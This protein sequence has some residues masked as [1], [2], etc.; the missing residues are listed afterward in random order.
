MNIFEQ[1]FVALRELWDY[2][3]LDEALQGAYVVLKGKEEGPGTGHALCWKR[4]VLDDVKEAVV[5]HD[6]RDWL[7]VVLRT[8]DLGAILLVSVHLCPALSFADKRKSL[9]AIHA[10]GELLKVDLV[11][12]PGDYNCPAVGNSPLAGVLNDNGPW[13][14]YWASHPACTKTNFVVN[15]GIRRETAIDHIMVKG[16]AVLL[17][18]S[19]FSMPGTHLALYAELGMEGVMV[20]SSHWRRFRWRQ[21]ARRKRGACC[22]NQ[23]SLGMDDPNPGFD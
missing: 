2:K 19:T 15:N 13:K 11:L 22:S 4:W 5:V 8:N 10:A 7:G 17:K 20:D 18:T 12:A 3:P 21:L 9:E 6:N 1:T 16:N 23:C 14:E